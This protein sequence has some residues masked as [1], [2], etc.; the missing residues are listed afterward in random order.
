[1]VRP[2]PSERHPPWTRTHPRCT[3]LSPTLARRCAGLPGVDCAAELRAR[4]PGAL[5]ADG[6]PG[7]RKNDASTAPPSGGG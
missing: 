1:M 2:P 6:T 4:P 3:A 5:D 7:V